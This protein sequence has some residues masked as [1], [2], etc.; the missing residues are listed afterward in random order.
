MELWT[1]RKKCGSVQKRS[2]SSYDCPEPML[3]RKGGR[4]RV[5]RVLGFFSNRPNW[6][7][8]T[9]PPHQLASVSSPSFVSGWGGGGYTLACG[10][11]CGGSQF[12]RG[13]GHC[14]TLGIYVLC[15]ES[16]HW[17]FAC[18]VDKFNV[19][20][21]RM[22]PTVSVSWPGRFYPHH[23]RRVLSSVRCIKGRWLWS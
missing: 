15:E 19:R 18:G 5:D 21:E 12:R 11:G 22:L 14:A 4:H 17:Y 13:D 1:D 9:S 6:D 7:S 8:P 23:W 2:P 3:A 10:R 16:G 20:G